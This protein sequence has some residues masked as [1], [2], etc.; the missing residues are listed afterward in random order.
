LT[1]EPGRRRSPD[2][3]IASPAVSTTWKRAL[4]TGASSG[5]GDAIARRL[6]AEGTDLVVVARDRKRLEALAE[7]LT[8]GQGVEVEVLRADLAKRAGVASVVERLRD[9]SA[10][11]D[12]LVNNAGFGTYGKFVEL[13]PDEEA[14]EIEVNCQALVRLCH[15]AA[16]GM[17][18][19]RSGTIVNVSSLAS[20]AAAPNN[21]VY[22]ATKAFV[23]HFSEALHEELRGTGVTVTV[24]EPGFTRTEFQDR[25][26]LSQDAGMPDF[27]WQTADE[28]ADATLAG[29]R[30][31]Q[32]LVVPGTHNR[33]AAGLSALVPRNVKRRAVGMMSGRF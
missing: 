27:V 4:V 12:L 28:V 8:A 26:G 29:A 9:E 3:P 6:A 5:I 19:R 25:A 13:D 24:V 16:P 17:V 11:V 22:A 14:R 1:T 20:R 15:A 18:E 23:S 31:G 2:A 7:E 21:A 10:P 32:A 33:V 30:K